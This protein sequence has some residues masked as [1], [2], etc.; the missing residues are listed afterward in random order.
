MTPLAKADFVK[1]VALSLGSDCA[2]ITHAGPVGRAGYYRH[3]LAAGYAGSMTY[4]GRNVHLRESPD[5]L[6]PGA[7]SVICVGVSYRRPAVNAP[8]AARPAGR[9]ATY[10]RGRDY[11]VVLWRMLET[12]VERLRRRLDE[13]FDAR[14]CV[15]TA[16]VLEREL[17]AAA[18]L[19]WIGKN[20]CLI[21]RELGSYMLLGEVIT[22]LDL[23]CDE[24]AADSCGQC[25]RCIEACP[26]GAIVEPHR[27]NASRCVSYLTIEH[28]GE[29][30]ADLHVGV[31]DRVFG[32]D[33]CQD[34][35]P[36]NRE[37]PPATNADL[38]ADC[39]PAH[40]DLLDTL[41]L[42][43]AAYRRLT[44]G[45]AGTRASR[46]MWRRNAAIALG[47]TRC[48]DESTRTEIEAALSEAANDNNAAVR[49]AAKHALQRLQGSPG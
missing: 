16:P 37:A 9:V 14:I 36:Y 7:R 19:G 18:G 30:P 34:V 29:V 38:L 4:L 24:P 23:A 22:T 27:L 25:T 39:T 15:D 10:A 6:L 21:S 12:L 40:V 44:K 26:T 13:P 5:R 8:N 33:A 47:N 41:Q 48:D 20:T 49:H 1:Q 42:G 32:C 31:G 17:A 28:R 45:T 46:H 35:C 2:G 3:W 11:H 43:S